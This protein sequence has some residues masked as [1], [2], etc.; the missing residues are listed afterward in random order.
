MPERSLST[1]QSWLTRW[2]QWLGLVVGGLVL[3]L[4]IAECCALW[5]RPHPSTI[6]AREFKNWGNSPNGPNRRWKVANVGPEK[7]GYSAD[8][9]PEQL[10]T[11]LESELDPLWRATF[12]EPAE[13][14]ILEMALVEQGFGIRVATFWVDVNDGS[15]LRN[16]YF[17]WATRSGFPFKCLM[18]A[19]HEPTSRDVTKE[20]Y[21]NGAVPQFFVGIK[22]EDPLLLRFS[23][24]VLLYGPLWVGLV[25]NTAIY[26]I[27]LWC[28]LILMRLLKRRLR[29]RANRCLN[30]GY[31]LTGL[32]NLSACPECGAAPKP[33]G[34]F[35]DS[36]SA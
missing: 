27:C 32:P 20:P 4:L 31:N 7:D 17:L 22:R 18:G 19:G 9:T 8:P 26:S 29:L 10:C 1:R 3:S 28:V 30:C 24:P 11:R 5:S 6:A 23:A 15:G 13:W 25:A 35:K 14:H 33:I 2:C 34:G 21:W 12:L 16:R 36:A